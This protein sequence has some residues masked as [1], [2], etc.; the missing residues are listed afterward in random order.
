MK[1]GG[2]TPL[3]RSPP[4]QGEHVDFFAAGHDDASVAEGVHQLSGLTVKGQVEGGKTAVVQSGPQKLSGGQGVDGAVPDRRADAAGGQAVA[5]IHRGAGNEPQLPDIVNAVR[6]GSGAEKHQ[7][8]AAVGNFIVQK[9][10]AVYQHALGG[11]LGAPIVKGTHLAG[12][13]DPQHAVVVEHPVGDVLA[14]RHLAGIHL[15]HLEGVEDAVG[16]GAE[17]VQRQRPHILAVGAVEAQVQQD[18]VFVSVGFLVHVRARH[19]LYQQTGGI[20]LADH[21]AQILLADAA[22]LHFLA[23]IVVVAGIAV[24]VQNIHGGAH[25]RGDVLAVA[26]EARVG[27]QLERPAHRARGAHAVDAHAVVV[28]HVIAEGLD[29]LIVGTG[30]PGSGNAGGLLALHQETDTP[31]VRRPAAASAAI[32]ISTAL[33]RLILGFTLCMTVAFLPPPSPQKTKGRRGFLQS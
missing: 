4:G 18:Q 3:T 13:D 24:L 28:Q 20:G 17:H 31:H 7:R 8:V 15:A 6:L 27:S 30:Q 9:P 21:R 33:P 11:V 12:V 26:V 29:I 19:V 25:P 16:G 1:R 2:H 23:Q 14:Q 32:R 22:E 5:L 10:P